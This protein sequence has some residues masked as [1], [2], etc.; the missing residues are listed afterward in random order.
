MEALWGEGVPRLAAGID[1]GGVAVEQAVREEAFAQVEPDPLDGVQLGCVGGERHESD[2]AGHTEVARTVPARL[3]QDE[4]GVHIGSEGGRE[5]IEEQVHGPGGDHGQ[6][7]HKALAC[8]GS[9][10]GVE[11]GPVIALVAKPARALPPCPPAMAGAAFLAHSGLILEPE[12]DLL[13][14]MIGSNGRYGAA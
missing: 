8:C 11:V 4:D 7:E 2:I 5:A 14:W 10:G 13:T 6:D 1:N 9:D 12:L 3:V